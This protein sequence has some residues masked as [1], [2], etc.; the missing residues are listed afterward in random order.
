MPEM[1][2]W[3]KISRHIVEMEGYFGE[4]FNRPMCW[5]DLLL[6]A[7]WQTEKVFFIRGNKVIVKRG[8]IAISIEDLSK[9]WK[10]SK[11]TVQKRLQEFVRS[12]RIIINRSNVVNIITINNY[13]KYQSEWGSMQNGMQNEGKS[14]IQNSMQ[15]LKETDLFSNSCSDSTMNNGTQNGT[16]T[17]MQNS[18]ESGLPIKNIKNK[19]IIDMGVKGKNTRFSPPTIEEIR[20]YVQ[21]KGYTVDAERF[22]NFYESKGWYVGKNKMKNWHAAVATWQKSENERNNGNFRQKSEN[23]RGSLEVTATGEED[24]STSF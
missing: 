6:L 11:T 24:Y 20:L 4:K 23:R 8:Q 10:I 12:E 18:T 13:E 22:V 1:N 15:K 9:R 3:I 2:G 21:E 14:G 7:E 19:E 17:G 5:I 16:Q